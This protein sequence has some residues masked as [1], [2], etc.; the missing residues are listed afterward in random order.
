MASWGVTPKIMRCNGGTGF[1]KL[2]MQPEMRQL[3]PAFCKLRKLSVR[4]IFV[5]FDLLWTTA[6]LLAAPCIEIL[7]IEVW[8]HICDVD[9][10]SRQLHTERRSP[11]WEMQ[12]DG[13][14]N[15]SMLERAP[16]LQMIILKGDER[17]EY[18]DALDT[19][20]AVKFPK[21]GEQEMVVRRIRDGIFS[22]RIIF[23][24]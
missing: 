6:F 20:R 22:P 21:K 14:K 9:D 18:C 8:E 24:K 1:S 17:C 12:F 13:P 11:Q 4:G 2:W 19:P 7:H 23:D 15:R 5:E 16:N 10:K 3:L